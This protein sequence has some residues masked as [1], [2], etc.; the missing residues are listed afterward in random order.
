MGWRI[1]GKVIENAEMKYYT[2]MRVGGPVRYLIFPEDQNDLLETL[3]VL[4][5][6]G[7][8]WRI[9]GNGTNIV[10]SDRGL[11]EALIKITSFKNFSVNEFKDSA[12]VRVSGGYPLRKLILK[13]A[14]MGLSGLEKLYSI[15]GT[16]GGAIKMNAG[17][18]GCEIGDLV[19]KVRCVSFD[20]S[21]TEIPKEK[22]VF[23]Y[24]KSSFPSNM[25]IVEAELLLTKK[26]RK[27]IISELKNVFLERKRRHPLDLPSA[28]SIF[29]AVGG[30][31]AWIY[32]ERA[33]LK[34]LRVGNA[35]V[36]EKHCNFIVNLGGATGSDVKNLIEKIKKE[37]YEKE[38]VIL[39]E[40]IELWGFDD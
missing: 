20:L 12:I 15:P 28:G 11:N 10:V 18:F 8:K 26:D 21:V 32:I 4:N 29:K 39:E 19:K 40:E 1:K 7:I 38:G 33:N 22:M 9:L 25:C 14:K 17:S 27:R 24:R 34:G 13:T 16:L 2:S 23:S 5:N 30:I 3:T 36:S 6:E 37:V 31:P 35:C